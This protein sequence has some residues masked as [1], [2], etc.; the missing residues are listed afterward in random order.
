MVISALEQTTTGLLPA[1]IAANTGANENSVR[2]ALNILRK[3][4]VTQKQGERWILSR[5]DQAPSL[6]A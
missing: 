6:A 4:N 2:G 5:P 1:E 3:R